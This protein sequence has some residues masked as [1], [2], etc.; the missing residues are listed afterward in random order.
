MK[1][2]ILNQLFSS[3]KKWKTL[4]LISMLLTLGV[5]QMRGGT[6]TSDGTAR[7]FFK[8]NAVSWWNAGTNGDGNFAYFYGSSGD[9]WSAHSVQQTDNYYYVVVPAGTWDHVILTRNNTSTSPS[10]SNKWNQTGDIAIENGKNYISA[11]S[12]NSAAA[13]WSTYQL[14]STGSLS[15]TKTSMTTAESSTLTPSLTSNTDYNV[16]TSTSYSVTTNPGSA[17]SVTSGGVFTATAAGTYVVTATVTYNA[18][19]FT[20]ITKTVSPT[21]NITVSAAA[22]TTHSVTI[23]YKCGSTTVSTQTSQN[24]GEVTAAS[25]TAPTV[26]GYTFSSWTLGN[27]IS[28]QSANTSANPISVK[29]KASGTYTMQANYTEDLSS[30]WTLKG[31][32]NVTGDNWATAHAMTKKTGHS[33]EN[34]AY[35]TANISSTNSGISGSADNWSFKVI[36]D[37][38]TWYGLFASGSY[39]WG[40]GTSANQP[41]TGE[42][43]IQICADVAGDYEVKVDYTD[44]SN[45]TVTVTFPT[46]YTLTYSIGSVAGTDGSISTSPTT[47]SGSKVLNGSS[48]TLTGPAAKTGYAWKGWYTNAAGTEGKVT[49]TN[50]AITVTMNDDKTLYAC[51]TENDYT[52]TVNAGTGG[53]VASGSVTGHYS[54]K[55]T[56]PTAT[57][58]PGYY[59]TGWTVTTGTATLTSASSA[60]A[61]QINGMTDAV[62]VRANFAPIWRIACSSDSYNTESHQITTITTSAGAMTSGSVTIDLDANTDYE[63]K[64]Y[65]KSTDK[66]WGHSGTVTKITYTNK[67]TAQSLSEATGNNQTFRTAG[68]GTYTFTWNVS[69]S[70][71]SIGYPTSYTV[72]FGYGTGGS[73]VTASVES[74]GAITSGQYAAAGKDITFTQTPA[75]GYELK[76]W[77]TASSGG[78]AVS[79]MST[80]DNVLDDIAANAN[81]YAQYNPKNYIITLDVDEANK[82]TITGATTSHSVTYN[83][84]VTNIP[85]LPTAAN[86]YGLDG[87]YTGQNGAG[88]KLFNSDGSCIASVSGYTD[89]NKKW[90]RDDN[91]VKLYA[92]YKKSEVTGITLSPAA[93]GTEVTVTATATIDPTPCGTTIVCWRL[94]RDNDTEITTAFTPVSGTP[95]AQTAVSFTSPAT[96]AYYKLEAKLRT[97]STCGSGT[98]LNTYVKRFQVAGTHT[99]TVNYTDGTEGIK[100][101]TS[102]SANPNEWSDDIT[103]PD[104]FGYTFSEWNAGTGVTIKD[105]TGEDL[106]TSTSATIKIKATYNGTLTAVYT[107]K[108]IVY[109]KDNL[110]WTDPDDAD[111]HIYVNLLTSDYWDTNNGSGNYNRSNCN[112]EMSRVPGTTDIFYYDYG[113]KTTSNYISFTKESMNNYSNF[114]QA[115]PNVAHVV[116]PCRSLDALNTDKATGLGFYAKT[117]MFVPLATQTPVKKNGNR[118]EYYN[119]GYWTKFTPGTGYSLDIYQSDG[120][121]H[122]KIIEFTSADELMPMKVVTDLEGS[123]TYKFQLKRDG[124]VYYGNSGTMT[125]TDH[126]QNTPWE[127]NNS[128]FSMCTIVTNAAGDYT[129]NLSFS[130]NSGGTN[131]RLRIEVDYP[132]ASGDYRLIYDDAVQANY[133]A[134]AIIPKKNSSTAI[135]S[136]FVRKNS[137][138][139]LRIQQASVANDGT[140]TW[141]EYPTSGTNTNQITGSIASAIESTPGVYN[142]NLSMNGSGALTVTSAEKYTGNFYIRTD[143]ANSKWDNY[144]TDPDHLMTYS[145]YSITHGGYSHYYAHWVDASEAGRKNVK[146]CIANDYSPSISDTLARETASGEWANI[147]HYIEEGGDL[148]RNANVRFMWNQAD[149]TIK[150]AYIDGAQDDINSFLELLSADSKIKDEAG[151]QVLTE[152]SFSDN[153]NWIYEANIKAQPNAQIKLKSTWG[154]TAGQEIEQY[155]VGTSSTTET[156][157]GGSGSVWYD[158]RLLYDFKTNR[159][160]AAYKPSGEIATDMEIHAD[161]MFIREAQ[162]DIAQLTFTGS[163][164]IT[165]IKTAYG[166]MKFSKWT[167]N[168]KSKEGG[169][170]PLVPELSPHQRGNFYISFPFRV[171]LNEVFGFGTYGTHWVIQYYD[172]AKRAREGYWAE[173]SGFWTFVWDRKNFVLEPNVG[174]LLL[175]D[176][177]LLGESSDVWGPSSRSEQIELFFPSYGEMPDLTGDN[178]TVN[179]PSHECKI[180]RSKDDKG[181]PTGLPDTG[182][183]RTSYNRTVFDS[184]WNVMGVPTYVNTDK[185]TFANTDWI[186]GEDETV[187]GPNFLYEWQMNDNSLVATA[188]QGYTYHA[189]HSY[190]VQYY[191]NVVWAAKSGSAYPPSVVA[192]RDYKDKLQSVEF[193][194]EVQQNDKMID[195]TF[196]KLSEDE[197]VNAGFSFNEDMTKIFNSRNANIYTFI[198][199]I[200]AAGNTMPMDFDKT[201]I[202]PVGVEIKAD[203]EYIFTMPDG[204]EGIGVILIDNETGARTNLALTD[205]AANLAAGNY[206][207]RFVLEISPI[208]QIVTNIESTEGDRSMDGV[209]K[210]LI[211][212]VLYIVKD[213]KVFDARG[214]RIQ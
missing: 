144:R 71:I 124:D 152:V 206:E 97:G 65:N 78:T 33:T 39:W 103:A 151:S 180:D 187:A 82:G 44:A 118:A 178:V 48:V 73:A 149:N 111:A 194:L 171:K 185:V 58:N 22:E 62:T 162:G 168:N 129:F 108:N 93:V 77:Y 83:T 161:V 21:V 213:G 214:A 56:L 29:T 200:K 165:D 89:A 63:F 1:T 134:S 4:V 75:T 20:G 119:D 143:C 107:Q 90:I 66:W 81:V 201:T 70:K 125:Y 41:L 135:V 130:P 13:T 61:A 208:E 153:E 205:Y 17:G 25:I 190:L 95:A 99:V 9:A 122:V 120:S 159:L 45:P 72:T 116:F 26:A 179:V 14:T 60:T 8:M 2:K 68:K 202:I 199:N 123:H 188:G 87:Y 148:K 23:T 158:I 128:P 183:P 139:D 211:D 69:N 109:F 18:I 85:N 47:A 27:G 212:G 49:D 11:F 100:A 91:S 12:E 7:L 3:C 145:E 209:C 53:S 52:V 154:V 74:S 138:P 67:G 28:N 166:V 174:Y 106:T 19:G 163:G 98:V 203:G 113:N 10:W 34:V 43:N 36:K 140:I 169:H 117:P 110:G 55:V 94:L 197:E 131:N 16:I 133:K 191:G 182:D 141:N 142:F 193:R 156:L 42:Q 196:V 160:V 96:S 177:D 132:V 64:V 136:F 189:M 126:G 104:I 146:F 6:I 50:R 170:A 121:T 164:A 46:A 195:Q 112:L 31:G 210:K 102:V 40:R 101:S 150:R 79:G 105:G 115:S 88:T 181:N 15:A 173:S 35:Y 157:I 172:G 176:L 24:I 32:T 80:S 51:Y 57:A 30:P 186:A 5:G 38:S 204:T 175:L 184:H 86:G 198:E 147:T 155:F 59:F 76:G 207:E 114:Y 37:G 192:R 127:F 137:T 84:V 92:Y 54:T 167:L